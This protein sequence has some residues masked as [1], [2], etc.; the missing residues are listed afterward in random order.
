MCQRL[1]YNWIM[2]EL[3]IPGRGVVKLDYLVCDVNGTLTLDGVLLEGVARALRQLQDRLTIHLVTADTHG[4]Q[5]QID[6]LLSLQSTRLARGSEAEQKANFIRQLG[7][8]RAAAIG[9]GANDHMMMAAAAIGIAVC[10]KEGLAVQTLLAADLVVPDIL[11][12]LE[13]FERPMRFVAS[14]RQ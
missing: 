14:L 12:A 4:R 7:A 9:Q 3:N 13:L 8:E 5:D 1:Y 10:S 6:Q 2:I 11:T